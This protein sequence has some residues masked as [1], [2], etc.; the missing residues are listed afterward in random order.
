MEKYKIYLL[1]TDTGSLFTKLIKYFTKDT[2]NHSSLSLDINLLN[3]Y[4]F[5]RKNPRNPLSGGFVKEDIWNKIYNVFPETTCALYEIEVNDKELED[6]KM[7]LEIFE[8]DSEKYGYNLIGLITYYLGMNLDVGE[9]YFCSEFVSTVLKEAK[10]SYS[11]K[12]P[13]KI[14]P[15]DLLSIENREVRLVYEGGLYM[16]APNNV[17]IDDIMII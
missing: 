8:K 9:R 2:Y 15:M 6:L 4:S 5:G 7:I 14:K 1:L 16:Y 11:E 13:S 12:N 10:I 3:V 17:L